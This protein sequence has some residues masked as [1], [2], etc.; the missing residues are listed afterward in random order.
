M[1]NPEGGMMNRSVNAE[2]IEDIR[3][4]ANPAIRTMLEEAEIVKPGDAITPEDYEST[5]SHATILARENNFPASAEAL[6][7]AAFVHRKMLVEGLGDEAIKNLPDGA[8]RNVIYVESGHKMTDEEIGMY[9]MSPLGFEDW[10]RER[11][12]AKGETGEAYAAV[13]EKD[14]VVAQAQ[15]PEEAMRR[16]QDENGRRI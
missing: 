4:Y 9:R 13:N 3:D 14:D 11:A 15:S 7:Q 12:A 2:A 10:L 5:K 16:A 8:L 6:L 1:S